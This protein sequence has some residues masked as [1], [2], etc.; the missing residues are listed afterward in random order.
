MEF[1]EAE[2]FTKWEKDGITYN[3]PALHKEYAVTGDVYSTPDWTDATLDG[4]P[5]GKFT[6][7][8]YIKTDGSSKDCGCRSRRCNFQYKTKKEIDFIAPISHGAFLFA[9]I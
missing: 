2:A 3:N 1:P 9:K 4:T 6:D 7:G 5:K 8:T